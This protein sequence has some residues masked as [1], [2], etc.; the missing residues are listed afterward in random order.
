MI[1]RIQ[2]VYLFLSMLLLSVL[3]SGIEIVSFS[4][5]E[6]ESVFSVFGLFWLDRK[7]GILHPDLAFPYYFFVILLI[8]FH[9]L[10]LFRFKKLKSQ[11]KLAQY[12]FLAYV[13]LGLVLLIYALVGNELLLEGS[14]M[15]PGVGLFMFLAG[16]PCTFLAVR[17]I[18]KDKSL[19][20]SVDR[21]R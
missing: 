6:S 7:S 5:G 12:T 9:A 1:Q 18:K 8:L 4:N 20:D 14:I 2:S 19:I 15:K 16:I 10:T 21:I 13:I 3:L 11:L 17:S